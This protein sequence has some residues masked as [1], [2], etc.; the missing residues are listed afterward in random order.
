MDYF[1]KEH[2]RKLWKPATN[3]RFTL[4]LP[5]QEELAAL[6]HRL[7]VKLPASYIELGAFSQN[8]GFLKRNGVPL[9]DA[10]GTITEYIKINHINPIGRTT[11]EPIYDTPR[12]FYDIPNLLVLGENWDAYYEFFVLR[13]HRIIIAT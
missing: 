12:P 5:G 1:T 3:E 11:T 4:P 2:F 8:G 7:G 9:R 13:Q 10:S 6:E